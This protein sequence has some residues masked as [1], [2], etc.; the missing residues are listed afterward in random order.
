LAV[1]APPGRART[2]CAQDPETAHA[3][4]AAARR[5][6]PG[7]SDLLLLNGGRGIGLPADSFPDGRVDAL[8]GSNRKNA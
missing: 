4:G 8:L 2:H 3:K 7:N 5:R 1:V 6:K